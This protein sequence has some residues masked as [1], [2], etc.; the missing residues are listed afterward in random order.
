MRHYNSKE[1]CAS[2]LANDT[3]H[4]HTDNSENASWR[5]TFVTTTAAFKARF[6]RPWHPLVAHEIFTIYFIRY[7]MMHL[8]DH[9]G[10]ASLLIGSVFDV[11]VCDQAG[12]LPGANLEARL[13]FLNADIR[14]FY[15]HTLASSRLPKLKLDSFH[16]PGFAELRGPLVKAANTRG[17]IPYTVAL[18]TRAVACNPTDDNKHALKCTKAMN[19][20]LDVLYRGDY[21]LSQADVDVVAMQCFKIGIHYQWLALDARTNGVARWAQRPKLHLLV[22]HIP[23][24]ARLINPVRVQGYVNESMVGTVANIYKKSMK[25]PHHAI[26]AGVV[27]RKYCTGLALDWMP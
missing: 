7:D 17:I 22:G 10:V 23:S 25:G 14:G 4:P 2:C 21:F 15:S 12:P 5:D 26:S 16:G 19:R 27:M 3:N 9:H 24:Q 1:I 13:D 20:L 11:Q 8:N 6:R 18:Q